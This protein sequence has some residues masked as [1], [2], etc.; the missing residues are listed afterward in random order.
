MTP[1][2]ITVAQQTPS[3]PPNLL[4]RSRQYHNRVVRGPAQAVRPA[5]CHLYPSV[6]V[7]VS[8]LVN[9]DPDPANAGQLNLLE[10]ADL[11]RHGGVDDSLARHGVMQRFLHLKVL[12]MKSGVHASRF[13]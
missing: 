5:F 4:I 8:G 3:R 7:T 11:Q 1:D 2:P 9:V 13:F 10:G 12:R 6:G